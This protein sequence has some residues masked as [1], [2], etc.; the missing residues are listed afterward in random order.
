MDTAA[1]LSGR[2]V[3]LNSN[4][5]L[6]TRVRMVELHLPSPCIL[7]DGA[8]LYLYQQYA[9]S[10]NV[11]DILKTVTPLVEYFTN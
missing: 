10:I 4:L 1:G 7:M 3:K 11:K 8:Q 9:L 6:G 2:C 5:N